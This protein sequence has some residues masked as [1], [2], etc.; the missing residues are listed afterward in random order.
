MSAWHI[1]ID[2]N[3]RTRR[4]KRPIRKPNS[5]VKIDFAMGSPWR[6]S[7]RESGFVWEGDMNHID[8]IGVRAKVGVAAVAG[9][10]FASAVASPAA[11]ETVR[12]RII[13]GV[14]PISLNAA[15]TPPTPVQNVVGNIPP[16]GQPWS[17]L[18][19]RAKVDLAAGRVEFE[20][21]GLVLAGGNS[22]GTPGAVNQV[23][24]TLICG[25][26]TTNVTI[27]TVLVPLSAKGDAEFSG[28]VGP[29]PSTCTSS[30][31]AFLIRIAAGRWIANGAVRA[32][33]TDQ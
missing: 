23:K 9:A 5:T 22:I 6:N 29:I 7:H 16:G 21:E 31:V 28:S 25:A 27:D 11:A 13:L 18:G 17:T 4:T 33:S 15:T 12:W 2:T 26:G 3:S 1:R 20:V 19:G 30:N 8:R 32:S 10:L 14:S 24:G